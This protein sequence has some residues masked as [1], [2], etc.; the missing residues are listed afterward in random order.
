M[1]NQQEKTLLPIERLSLKKSAHHLKPVIQ[2]GKKGITDS[3]IDEIDLAL[4]AHEL[5]KIQIL[6]RHKENLLLD[7]AIIVQRTEAYHI[8]T[9]GHIVIFFR[10]RKVDSHY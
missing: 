1:D 9:I 5:I 7:V 10:K 3:L 8:D 4:E 2:V 6:P